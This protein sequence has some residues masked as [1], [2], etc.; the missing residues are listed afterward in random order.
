MD[1][2]IEKCKN[3][4]PKCPYCSSGKCNVN[5][6]GVIR[7]GPGLYAPEDRKYRRTCGRKECVDTFRLKELFPGEIDKS[8]IPHLYKKAR[9]TDFTEK[10]WFLAEKADD[11]TI[12]GPNGVGKS[13]MAAAW[14]VE[15]LWRNPSIQ[16]KWVSVPGLMGMCRSSYHKSAAMSEIQIVNFYTKDCD[17]LIL[18]DLGAEKVNDFSI[19]TIYVIISNRIQWCKRT[20][21]TTNLTFEQLYNYDER[22]ASRISGFTRIKLDGPD[23]RLLK[24]RG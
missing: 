12:T 8:E 7:V 19:S 18:D 14:M 1:A 24:K 4:A 11:L 21:V 15:W 13:H 23:R 3:E 20:C 22:L 17:L 16:A 6:D 10:Q 9:K 5:L 2:Y